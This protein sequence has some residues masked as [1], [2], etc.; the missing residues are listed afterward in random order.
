MSLEIERK[1]LPAD[2]PG[3]IIENNDITVLSEQRMEQTYLAIDDTQ[4]VR[5]R[6]IEDIPTGQTT[7]TH[8]FKLGN[9]LKREEIEYSISE[10]IYYQLVKAF[11]YVPLTKNRI[12]AKWNE[13]II[14]IDIYDQIDLAVLEVEFESVEAANAFNP[15]LWFGKDISSAISTAIRRYGGSCKETYFFNRTIVWRIDIFFEI[16]L[17]LLGIRIIDHIWPQDKGRQQ[18]SEIDW[19]QLPVET[20]SQT[21]YTKFPAER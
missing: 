21:W 2:S 16:K 17:D 11:G 3:A 18:Q 14:E 6:K 9:G 20:V 15:P 4:E 5:V 7:Y 10:S 1:F 13:S 19:Q 8:T 12:T